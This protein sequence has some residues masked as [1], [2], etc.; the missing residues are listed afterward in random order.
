MNSGIYDQAALGAGLGPGTGTL[1]AIAAALLKTALDHARSKPSKQGA[2]AD[3]PEMVGAPSSGLP[4]LTMTA[5]G[6]GLPVPN[7]GGIQEEARSPFVPAVQAPV[8]P[9][10]TYDI[11]GGGPITNY[12]GEWTGDAQAGG[13]PGPPASATDPYDDA[14]TAL[15]RALDDRRAA[16]QGL[17]GLQ[18]PAP[19]AMHLG[20]GKAALL[21]ALSVLGSLVSH[22]GEGGANF[23]QGYLGGERARLNDSN[24]A[25]DAQY[26]ERLRRAGL[27]AQIAGEGVS[28]AQGELSRLDNDAYR[29]AQ[30]EQRAGAQNETAVSRIATA[31]QSA[32]DLP[33]M[34]RA[35]AR[36]RRLDPSTAPSAQDVE[37]AYDEKRAQLKFSAISQWRSQY[38]NDLNAFGEISEARAKELDPIR[39]TIASLAGL[40]PSDLP[41]PPTGK[42]VRMQAYE[43][44]REEFKARMTHVSAMDRE[45]LAIAKGNLSV[46][47]GHLE[48]AKQNLATSRDQLSLAQYQAALRAYEL[49]QKGT[50]EASTAA[51]MKLKIQIAGQEAKVRDLEAGLPE[52]E[53][54]QT[55]DQSEAIAKAR[56]ELSAMYAERAEL[57]AMRQWPTKMMDLGFLGQTDTDIPNRS[58][59]SA[60]PPPPPGLKTLQGPNGETL[61]KRDTAGITLTQALK[62]AYGYVPQVTVSRAMAEKIWSDAVDAIQNLHADP[63]QVLRAAAKKLRGQ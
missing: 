61:T 31:F 55:Q 27:A 34:E 9:Q 23:I 11:K 18:R 2:T 43:A 48:I 13:D 3:T 15:A 8:A 17:M 41:P 45:R 22:S 30:M 20:T 52:D 37:R 46:A 33:T 6:P 44:S 24:S 57:Q 1:S 26:Q 42:S 47:R 36:W 19:Q 7:A 14:H 21:A 32:K 56:A 4:D 40:D 63:G 51:G 39:H 62:K 10:A 5:A 28:N 25:A 50:T 12:A 29:R 49:A 35:A 58:G 59:T 60:P 38:Q 53:E 54:D 16:L